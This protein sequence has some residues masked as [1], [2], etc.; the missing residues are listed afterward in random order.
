MTAGIVGGILLFL[1]G[2]LAGAQGPAACKGP[3]ELETVVQAKPSVA[4]Y[5]ALGAWFGEHHQISCAVGAF[6]SAVRIDPRSWEAQYNLAL[7]LLQQHKSSLAAEHL[8]L[9]VRAKPDLLPAHNALG[10]VFMDGG[11]LPEA[12]REFREVLRLDA[13]NVYA[14]DLLAQILSSQHRYVAA[15]S[16]WNQ[17][18]AIQPGDAAMEIAVAVAHSQNGDPK[19]AIEILKELIKAQPNA[20]LAHFNLA[21]IYAHQSQFREAA[22]EYQEAL[23]LDPR[24]DTSRLSLVKA[25]T[26]IGLYSDALEPAQ[27]YAKRHPE[28]YEGRYLLGAIYRGLGDLEKAEP[29]LKRAASIK[30]DDSEVQYNLGFVLAKRGKPQEALPHLEKA[31]Q[32]K[33]DSSE[34]RFQLTGVLRALHQDERA[35]AVQEEFQ[36]QKQQ[37]VSNK[38]VELEGIK[39]NSLLESGD[40]GQAAETYRKML[41]MEPGDAHTWYN[42][43]LS[44]EKLGDRKGERDA[45]EKAVAL[46]SKMAPAY[47]QLAVLDLGEDGFADAERHL[48]AALTIDPQFAE[49][50]GNLGVIYDRQGKVKEA[51]S[52]FRQ[53]VE[54]DPQ[55][56]QGYLNLGVVLAQQNRLAEAR[57]TLE[58]AV[59]LAPEDAQILTALGMVQG[60]LGNGPEA[61]ASFRRV[62][63]LVPA[64]AE[65]H[66]NLGIALAD[67]Y[68]KDGAFREFTEAGRLAPDAAAVHYNK[69]RVLMDQRHYEEARVE[70][71]IACREATQHPLAHYMLAMAEKNL[72]HSEEAVALLRTVIKL[73]PRNADAFYLLG[74][75]LQD[76]GNS[77]EAVEAWKKSLVI[78]PDQTQALFNLIRALHQT[79]PAQAKQYEARF[80]AVKE[81]QQLTSEVETLN[82]FALA[83][84]KR[85]DWPQALEQMREAIR[86]CGECS[87]KPDLHKNFGLLSCQSGDVET[88][89]KE[90]RLALALK[91]GDQDIQKAI[92]IAASVRVAKSSTHP[93]ASGGHGER[94]SP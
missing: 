60:R 11:K 9:A 58:K 6:E 18:L 43:A 68:D 19:Q 4:A 86:L 42:L 74:R 75:T 41:Q 56:R 90:L 48:Q 55:Y 5:D 2:S 35:R 46:D 82:N 27:E 47:N 20:P 40:A 85:L 84:A 34:A 49:A 53:A 1:L 30:P 7:A 67:N 10:T 52:L 25:L 93:K 88:G 16:Y 17:A 78:D 38:V 14:L 59:A 15:I 79:D 61:I 39:A 62:I 64:S 13:K 3:A 87:F 26:T 22:D 29:E 81:K 89:E 80:V 23:H 12:E 54:N 28:D 21:T 71:E 65:A 32:L 8:S 63:A 73:D 45:L 69:G 24:D 44:L 50:Q 94:P 36:K 91:P 92:A 31:L 72:G 77:K 66:L 37:D 76:T 70:L 33:P 57:D 83:S 51:E